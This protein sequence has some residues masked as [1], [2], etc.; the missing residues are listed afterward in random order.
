M[1]RPVS[2][3][4]CVLLLFV[5]MSIARGWWAAAITWALFKIHARATTLKTHSMHHTARLIDIDK[6]IRRRRQR[7]R[8]HPL[9]ACCFLFG[10]PNWLTILLLYHAYVSRSLLSNRLV[11]WPVSFFHYSKPVLYYGLLS[12]SSPSALRF[13]H[14]LSTTFYIHT[15]ML[16][17]FAHSTSVQ[18]APNGNPTA[19]CAVS[20][21]VV[22]IIAP[23]AIPSTSSF[24]THT[25]TMPSVPSLPTSQ[26]N[27]LRRR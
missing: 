16:S 13:Y 6:R 19:F 8:E 3:S 11:W 2:L 4:L 12:L 18:P 15:V 10:H 17:S 1:V 24:H 5:P 14:G 27:N 26:L 20:M 23:T 7:T 22:T 21:F 25:H 9:P